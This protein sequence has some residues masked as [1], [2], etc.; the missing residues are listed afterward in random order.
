[1]AAAEPHRM[2]N[3]CQIRTSDRMDRRRLAGHFPRPF[4]RNAE[5]ETGYPRRLGYSGRQKLTTSPPNT[6]IVPP[7]IDGSVGR[8]RKATKL[9]ICHITNSVAM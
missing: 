1:L 9:T 2:T 4:L 5:D 6:I 3:S 7:T 8:L